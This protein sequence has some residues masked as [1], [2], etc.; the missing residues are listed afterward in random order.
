MPHTD[1]SLDNF[2]G[3][4]FMA[5]RFHLCSMLDTYPS[6]LGTITTS[7]MFAKFD[8]CTMLDTYSSIFGI[9]RASFVAASLYLCTMPQTDTPLDNNV[10][11]SFTAACFGSF[12]RTMLDTYSSLLGLITTSFMFANFTHARLQLCTMPYA[13]TSF[14]SMVGAFSNRAQPVTSVHPI[15]ETD[16]FIVG[17]VVEAFC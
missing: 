2:V 4:S 9:C 7:F 1:T 10:G 12:T 3:A 16:S 8:L 11:A 13:N 6:L 14:D 15:L 5:A 17:S